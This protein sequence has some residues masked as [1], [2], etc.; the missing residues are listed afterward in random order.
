MVA[1]E[2]LSLAQAALRDIPPGL[3]RNLLVALGL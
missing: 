3:L 2:E 1:L